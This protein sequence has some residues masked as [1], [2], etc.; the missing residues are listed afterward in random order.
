M[1]DETKTEV[2]P[3]GE[4]EELSQDQKG[5]EPARG[6]DQ[7]ETATGA[8][9]QGTDDGGEELDAE[10]LR[11]QLQNARKDAAKYRTS[12]REL[13]EALAQAKSPEDFQ[14]VQD[15]AEKAERDLNRERAARRHQLPEEL[16]EYLKGD[17]AEELEESAKRLATFASRPAP[18]AGSGGGGLDPSQR[19]T[20]STPAELAAQ[21]PR[22]R[23]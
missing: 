20:P 6:Q 23:R 1:S 19:S 2:T 7:S 13:R 9:D 22:S 16:E 15:R 5:Q 14:A 21:I 10:A 4:S 8:D 3:A 11:S 17:T 12:A 18:R